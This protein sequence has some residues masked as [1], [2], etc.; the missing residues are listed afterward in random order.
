MT[1]VLL[2]SALDR[3]TFSLAR[4][5]GEA[6]DAAGVELWLVGGPVRDALLGRPVLDLDLTSETPAGELG[7]LL[8]DR[9]GGACNARSQFGTLKLRIGGC[10]IDLATTRNERYAS[11]G[12]LPAVSPGDIRADLARRDFTINAMAASLRPSRRGELLDTQGGADDLAAGLVRALHERSFQDDP[13]RLLRAVRYTAR[14]G[15]DVEPATRRWLEGDLAR[16]GTVSPARLRREIERLLTEANAPAA[17]LSA[18]EHGVL[19][20]IDPGLGSTGVRDALLQAVGRKLSG[21]ALL[22]ALVYALPSSRATAL[23]ARIAPTKRQ[24]QVMAAVQR[25]REAEH[26]LSTATLGAEIEAAVDRAPREAVRAVAAATANEMVRRNL[27]RFL[28]ATQQRAPLDGDE[29][30]ALGVAP[31][32]AVGEMAQ[33]L[34]HALMDRVID[35]RKEAVLYVLRRLE[36]EKG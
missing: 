36:E 18:V 5:L 21:L 6:A 13:T 28:D 31:G 27:D 12:A 4:R 33:S 9:L 23:R 7:P 16:L 14:L 19:P 3:R 10:A 24:A 20:A 32:P 22:G 30:I 11:P 1:S 17:L 25:L 26:R 2:E 15:F 35:G 29:L 8:A 34:R